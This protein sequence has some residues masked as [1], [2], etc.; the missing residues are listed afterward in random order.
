[1]TGPI[2][3]SYKADKSLLN[4][5]KMSLAAKENIKST[6]FIILGIFSASFGLKGFLI[7]NQFIDGG[8]T[9]ISLLISFSVEDTFAYFDLYYKCAVHYTRLQ[10]DIKIFRF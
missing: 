6:I 7:P 1:M 3:R 2:N 5:Y 10:P 9:G 8:V 4:Y